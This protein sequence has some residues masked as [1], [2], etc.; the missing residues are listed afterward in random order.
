M[1]F[2]AKDELVVGVA[3]ADGVKVEQRAFA[4]GARV[5][6]AFAVGG[7][8]DGVVDTRREVRLRAASFLRC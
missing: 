7:E 5:V 4:V 3:G 6:E 8:V 1:E 2:A